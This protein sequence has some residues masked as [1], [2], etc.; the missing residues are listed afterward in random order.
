MEQ[1]NLVKYALKTKW[2]GEY[3]SQG[4]RESE[5]K[6]VHSVYDN[7]LGQIIYTITHNS[8][9]DSS[10]LIDYPED[11]MH[12]IQDGHSFIPNKIFDFIQDGSI[13]QCPSFEIKIEGKDTITINLSGEKEQ[14]NI[15]EYKQDK[16]GQVNATVR[17]FTFNRY[18][19][20]SGLKYPLKPKADSQPGSLFFEEDLVGLLGDATKEVSL[21]HYPTI[22]GRRLVVFTYNEDIDELIHH[23]GYITTNSRYIAPYMYDTGKGY[24]INYGKIYGFVEITDLKDNFF[25][26]FTRDIISGKLNGMLTRTTFIPCREEKYGHEVSLVVNNEM[27]YRRFYCDGTLI[28]G[29]E[30]I[31]RSLKLK[32]LVMEVIGRDVSSIVLEFL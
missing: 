19:L 12:L 17:Y 8:E 5:I 9:D 29:C 20:Y 11:L 15:T 18:K 32:L 16:E 28:D 13:T 24:W 7:S 31:T 3:L 4:A 23:R 21:C 25:S 27:L 10:R 30:Y 6:P 14:T 2:N 22:N 1:K 26:S